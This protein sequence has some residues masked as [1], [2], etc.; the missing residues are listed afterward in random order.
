[1]HGRYS[2]QKYIKIRV[3]LRIWQ[4][5][6]T[7]ERKKKKNLYENLNS[8]QNFINTIKLNN[9]P[10]LEN[11]AATKIEQSL[12]TSISAQHKL[13][14]LSFIYSRIKIAIEDSTTLVLLDPDWNRDVNL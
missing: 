11:I 1:M 13:E 3:L 4:K 14:T 5:N 12:L 7:K 10:I 8:T 9:S 6:T 2:T